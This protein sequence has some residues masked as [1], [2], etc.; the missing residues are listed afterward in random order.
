MPLRATTTER[1]TVWGSASVR[2]IWIYQTIA[3]VVP[4]TITTIPSAHVCT[5]LFCSYLHFICFNV[6]LSGHLLSIAVCDDTTC[7]NHGHCNA[8]GSCVCDTGY[9]AS[10][11]CGSCG[12]NYF[13]YPACTCMF[14]VRR[15]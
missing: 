3:A 7:N 2:R 1:A 12:P 6:R 4:K 14:G 5:F 15:R 13:N 10:S 9:D 8:N 11:K